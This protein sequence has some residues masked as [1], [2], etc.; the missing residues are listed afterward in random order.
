[1]L[2]RT[3]GQPSAQNDIFINKLPI[4][5]INSINQNNSINSINLV[6]S[7]SS[8]S[9]TD[10]SFN[11]SNLRHLK[12]FR[13]LD[14]IN[15]S[16]EP[17]ISANKMNT[18]AI[19]VSNSV[20]KMSVIP[21]FYF[22]VISKIQET[23]LESVLTKLR[24]ILSSNNYLNRSHFGLITR[25]CGLPRYMSAALFCKM[26]EHGSGNEQYM[27]VAL[28]SIIIV[29]DDSLFQLED[30]VM[31]H[32]GLEFLR[33]N[34]IFRERYVETVICRLF[35]DYN[36]NWTGKMTYKEFKRID[37]PGMLRKLESK[38]DLNNTCSYFS[39][40]HFYV[41]YCKFWELDNDYDLRINKKDLARYSDNALTSRIIDRVIHG[42]G[43]TTDLSMKE[44]D[45]NN[46]K[47][48][49]R[50]FI[51]FLLS[52]VD[53]STNTSIE[54]WFRCLDNDG[55]GVL[56]V[57]ELEWF[58]EEQLNRMRLFG[59][60]PIKF[61][62]CICQMFDLIKPSNPYVITLKDLKRCKRNAPPFFDMLFNISKFIAYENY[63][64][65]LG[66]MKEID[67]YV[68][69][70]Y[71]KILRAEQNRRRSYERLET[72]GAKNMSNNITI[73]SFRNNVIG[74]RIIHYSNKQII[75][76][77]INNNDDDKNRGDEDDD[78][79]E[80]L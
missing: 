27:I 19:T 32:P 4:N 68:N 18:K 9:N 11:I 66:E 44:Y 3:T 47:M 55:D 22:P 16:S 67:A 42:Y 31:N 43:K 12:R 58:Y 24:E 40:N 35:Y 54:Y 73:D 79:K 80:L 46:P 6:S 70:E 57:Y 56:S 62:D 53:K 78:D 39:Y 10:Q 38:I 21:R 59:I 30:I 71:D 74:N 36:R 29:N 2:S 7:I 8:N 13:R 1:M 45:S 34:I 26:F 20:D 17:R 52:E 77:E 49:Y 65:Q 5:S 37:L 61:K 25:E 41:I 33:K 75:C 51:W 72:L 23:R 60:E 14:T 63:Q 50:D 64:Q 28:K 76:E 69:V 15:E 48:S